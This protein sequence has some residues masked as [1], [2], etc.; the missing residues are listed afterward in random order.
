MSICF[1][2]KE[3]ADTRPYGPGGAGVC[4]PC[5]TADEERN[6]AAQDVF[7]EGVRNTM[8]LLKDGGLVILDA[9]TGIMRVVQREELE[10]YGGVS[11]SELEN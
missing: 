10:Q 6:S 11:A 7:L 3:D 9:E 2:C 8:D 4:L 5:L 1:Y